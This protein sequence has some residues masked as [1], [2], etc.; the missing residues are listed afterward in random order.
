MQVD[1][2]VSW[3]QIRSHFIN[4]FQVAQLQDRRTHIVRDS[5]AKKN[6]LILLLWN[7]FITLSVNVAAD[8]QLTCLLYNQ[9]APKSQTARSN[10][11]WKASHT[12]LQTILTVMSH[13]RCF[14][15]VQQV[16]GVKEETRASRKNPHRQLGQHANTTQEGP[17]SKT[18]SHI[19]YSP[20]HDQDKSQQL[21]EECFESTPKPWV[22]CKKEKKRFYSAGLYSQ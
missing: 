12:S 10:Q 16:F 6:F 15:P 8:T 22:A 2:T 13:F 21:T 14:W 20:F 3:L 18:T 17:R 11:H 19:S 5:S 4:S 1:F 7:N 9:F